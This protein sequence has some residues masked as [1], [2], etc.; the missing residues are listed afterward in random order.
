MWILTLHVFLTPRR[1][2]LLQY[3]HTR[4]QTLSPGNQT[5]GPA[6][7]AG[8][9]TAPPP[10]PHAP[11]TWHTPPVSCQTPPGSCGSSWSPHDW[12]RRPLVWKYSG[13]MAR[14]RPIALHSPFSTPKDVPTHTSTGFLPSLSLLAFAI[15]HVACLST[16]AD[17][18]K[19]T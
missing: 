3:S 8:H 9:S 5:A 6:H 4:P 11:S 14:V 2:L 16:G 18:A 10:R 13:C 12:P 17:S 15:D 7:S 19:K 1:C